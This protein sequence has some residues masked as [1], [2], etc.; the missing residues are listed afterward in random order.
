MVKVLVRKTK[1]ILPITY[2]KCKY[3]QIFFY[4]FNTLK[5]I[6]FNLLNVKF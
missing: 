3:I 2:L 4:L 1:F 5:L 6:F